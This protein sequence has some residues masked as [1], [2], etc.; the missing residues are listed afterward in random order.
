L[1]LENELGIWLDEIEY[2]VNFE[3]MMIVVSGYWYRIEKKLIEVSE[4]VVVERCYNEGSKRYVKWV[5]FENKVLRENNVFL[6]QF[7]VQ[8]GL[9]WKGIDKDKRDIRSNL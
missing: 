5:E 1:A 2:P 6:I 3:K 8:F 7:L 4:L 9:A